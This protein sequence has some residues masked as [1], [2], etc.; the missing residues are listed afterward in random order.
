MFRTLID[1]DL[2]FDSHAS[3]DVDLH[4]ERHFSV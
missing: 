4:I 3:K 2:E 1:V